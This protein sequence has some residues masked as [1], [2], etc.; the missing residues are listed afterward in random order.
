MT[1]AESQRTARFDEL[2]RAYV[3]DIAAYCRWRTRSAA[4]ADDALAEV[5]LA[6]WRRLEDMP[7]S[8]PDARVWLY[9]TARRVTANQHRAARRRMGLVDRIVESRHETIPARAITDGPDAERV[10]AALAQLSA[11]DREALL[12]AEWE[13]LTTAEAASVMGCSENSARGRLHRAR[14]RFRAAY[15]RLHPRAA[16]ALD[17]TTAQVRP[18]LA[19]PADTSGR[20][21]H[22]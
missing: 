4:D 10:R 6:A 8:G 17:T 21:D 14:K 11:R 20:I 12:L 13:E 22:A 9:A 19:R 1:D 18:A 3:A 16:R 15:E 5:F 2:F 7:A